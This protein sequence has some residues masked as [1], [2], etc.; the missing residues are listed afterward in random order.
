MFGTPSRLSI[1]ALRILAFGAIFIVAPTIS[2]A[3]QDILSDFYGNTLISKD[4][5]YESHYY[6]KPDHTFTAALPAYYLVLKG[7]W[8]QSSDGQ[9]C[10]VF[11]TPLPGVKNPDCNVMLVHKVG[12]VDAESNGDSERLVEGLQ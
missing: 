8:S 7:T 1:I 6:Y 2:S 11:S 4:G 10:R 12:D 5:G 9:V 3:D